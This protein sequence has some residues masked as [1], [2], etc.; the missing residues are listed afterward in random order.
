MKHYSKTRSELS[1]SHFNFFVSISTI[2]CSYFMKFLF[3]VFK[4]V[5]FTTK[6]STAKNLISKTF[7]EALFS[8]SSGHFL[9]KRTFQRTFF[10]AKKTFCLRSSS[11]YLFIYSILSSITSVVASCT[12]WPIAFIWSIVLIVIV[13]SLDRFHSREQFPISFRVFGIFLL[14]H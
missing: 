4:I 11:V 10:S 3:S 2:F 9:V 6:G 13:F 5:F 14:L 12:L 8:V 1:G 7:R